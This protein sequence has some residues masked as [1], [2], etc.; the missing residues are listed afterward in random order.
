MC[1]FPGNR[2]GRSESRLTEERHYLKLLV[3]NQ[4]FHFKTFYTNASLMDVVPI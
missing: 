4:Q 3:Q 1:V 2:T